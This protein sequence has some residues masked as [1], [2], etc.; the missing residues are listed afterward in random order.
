MKG[1]SHLGIMGAKSYNA[2]TPQKSTHR[3]SMLLSP[4]KKTTATESPSSCQGIQDTLNLWDK[5]MMEALSPGVPKSPAIAIKF[6]G[7]HLSPFEQV[8]IH[9][10]SRI[11]FVGHQADKIHARTNH[12]ACN[13]GYDDEHGN[14]N[15]VIHDHLAYRYEVIEE[16]GRGSFGQVL[17]CL[18]HKTTS[19]VAIKLI[20]N[21]KKILEQ[22]KYEV[23]LLNNLAQWV[24]I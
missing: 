14:Y 21:K 22:A 13:Y 18:D 1:L 3:H 4:S 23:K 15:R 2:V 9:T 8:E 11:Y 5:E 24:L 20:R 17:K 10:Y 19:V 6:Y 12:V 7:H 16:L